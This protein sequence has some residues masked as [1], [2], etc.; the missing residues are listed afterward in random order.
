MN[1]KGFT[2][3]ELLIVIAIIALIISISIYAVL[4]VVK[5]AREKTYQI[6]LNNIESKISSYVTENNDKL[7]YVTNENNSYEYQCITVQNLIDYGYLDNNVINSKIS[8]DENVKADNYIYIERNP[9]T[10]AVTKNKYIEDGNIIYN[11]ICGRAVSATGDIVYT[12]API[13][14]DWSK[15]KDITITYRLNNISN[16]NMIND[17]NYNY[18]YSSDNYEVLNDNGMVK[19]IRIHENGNM[20]ADIKGKSDNKL[21]TSKNLVVTK[22]DNIGPTVTSDYSGD[23]IVTRTVTVPLLVTDIG[24]GV[25]Y[26]SFTL[27]DIVVTIGETVVN[28]GITLTKGNN[29]NYSLKIDNTE[30][31]GKVKITIAEDKVF[32][33][34]QNGNELIEIN[35][36]ITF[37]NVYKITF[38]AN[39]GTLN[40]TSPLYTKYNRNIAYTNNTFTTTANIPTVSKTGYTFNGWYTKS[41]GG[42]KVLNA[43][44]SFTGSAVAG[45]TGTNKWQP[46]DNITLY[47]QYTANTYT[48]TLNNQSATTAGTGTIYVKYGTGWYSNSGATTSIT[49][50]TVPSKTGYTF[51]GYYTQT[52]GSGT[53]VID[54]S[55]NIKSGNTAFSANTTVYA[56]WTVNKYTITLNN[57]S[58]TT[59]GTTAIYENY[60][61]G[62]YL[63]SA[64]SKKMTTS[65]NPI[66]LPTKNGYA[67][68]GYYTSTGG[69]GTQMINANGYIT[70]NFTST[71]YTAATTLYAAWAGVCSLKYY[72][73]CPE[74]QL[75]YPTGQTSIYSRNSSSNSGYLGTLAIVKTSNV[76]TPAEKVYYIGATNTNY[77]AIVVKLQKYCT[78]LSTYYTGNTS[79]NGCLSSD[80][81]NTNG[82]TLQTQYSEPAYLGY[83]YQGCIKNTNG[84]CSCTN[85]GIVSSGSSGSSGG[86]SCYQC[87]VEGSY[88]VWYQWGAASGADCTKLV[89][90]TS[91][92]VYAIN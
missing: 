7:F 26:D 24:I 84:T 3:I 65:A 16:T 23:N 33:K 57:Q 56:K 30:L 2:L 68:M 74:A 14:D 32:D 90:T 28:S 18:E 4:G 51:G 36:D 69:K 40:G 60:N 22:I 78:G 39:G 5:S 35:T 49:K 61:V 17:Y 45:Y 8:D 43:N 25:D 48:I 62:V 83:I 20:Y 67:F 88:A 92:E 63:D 66:T 46:S 31:D 71:K 9:S 75:C 53:Q 80:I 81:D 12:T 89:Q 73:N 58:A 59:A 27:D 6:T 50:I 47:A 70:S 19:I 82:F 10:K 21:L 91:C 86:R 37:N 44:G 79:L 15:Y 13:M 1:K 85:P 42:S 34:L 41:T 64:L 29:G 52:G 38:N 55:G 77:S 72:K 87:S 76:S 11:N 54:A